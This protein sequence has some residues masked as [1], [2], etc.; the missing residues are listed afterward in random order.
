LPFDEI[1]IAL[2]DEQRRR[3]F[4]L[5]EQ[6]RIETLPK[7]KIGAAELVYPGD[8][9]PGIASAKQGWGLAPATPCED[10]NGGERR[11]R[12][13]EAHDELAICDWPDRGR[14]QQSDAVD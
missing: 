8:L 11:S 13:P 12:R 14:A 2:C 4:G 7:G 6:P 1:E 9:S 10:G 3:I 5:G